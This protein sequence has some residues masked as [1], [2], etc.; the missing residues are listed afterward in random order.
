MTVPESAPA[1][2][3]QA[4]VAGAEASAE[5]NDNGE[6][7]WMRI[8]RSQTISISITA[9]ALAALTAIFFFQN[10]L[11]RRPTL[12]TWVAR[13]RDVLPEVNTAEEV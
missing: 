10:I 1:P 2:S 4:S 7:L 13:E 5:A 11:V 6:P 9:L 3:T 12:Y 8:W